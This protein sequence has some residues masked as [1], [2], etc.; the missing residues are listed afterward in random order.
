MI[1]SEIALPTDGWTPIDLSVRAVQ[2]PTIRQL[3]I[4]VRMTGRMLAM[5]VAARLRV[6]AMVHRG[7][8]AMTIVDRRRGSGDPTVVLARHRLLD[9]TI[10]LA[11]GLLTTDSVDLRRGRRL[12]EVT[13]VVLAAMTTFGADVPS[14]MAGDLT[15]GALD[16]A[17]R[18]AIGIVQDA[19]H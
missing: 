6:A 14:R 18:V 4:V 3:A 16:G 9:V 12:R 7:F 10:G 1:R 19:M 13:S 5:I 15:V 11:A 2:R 17:G 8:H